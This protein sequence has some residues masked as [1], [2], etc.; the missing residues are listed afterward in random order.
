MF[1]VYNIYFFF[2]SLKIHVLHMQCSINSSIKFIINSTKI[3]YIE[4]LND[5]SVSAII[6]CF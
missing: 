2:K 6:C 1:N 4:H 5:T 3:I